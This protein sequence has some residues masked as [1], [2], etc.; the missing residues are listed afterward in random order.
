MSEET[1]KKFGFTHRY[2]GISPN[3]TLRRSKPRLTVHSAVKNT[4][5]FNRIAGLLAIKDHM[6]A[7]VKFPVSVPNVTAIF[8]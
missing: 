7:S 8:T 4:Y 5:D 6:A 1:A 2:D 3:M